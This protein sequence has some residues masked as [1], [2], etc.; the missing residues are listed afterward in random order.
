MSIDY[1]QPGDA[2]GKEPVAVYKPGQI[3][4]VEWCVDNNGDHG[5]MFTYRLCEDQELV[6]KFL[7]PGYMPT[8]AEKQAAEDCFEAGT[9]PCTDVSGQDCGYNPECPQGSACYRN[10]WFT[11]KGFSEGRCKAVDGKPINSCATTIAGGY[12][13]SKK[14]KIPDFTSDHTLLSFKWNSYETGQIYLSCAD[15]A[16]RGDGTTPPPSTT[17]KAP[18]SSTDASVPSST[19]SEPPCSPGDKVAITFDQIAT[20]K[21]GETIKVVGSI[22]ALGSWDVSSAPALSA[23]GYSETK[24]LWSGKVDLKA[25][26]SLEYKFVRVGSSGSVAWESDPNR[27]YIVPCSDS[28]VDG[29]WR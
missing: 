8:D 21:V 23:S 2:W 3:V 6:D 14:I 25:G 11:C 29:K 22:P 27:K 10:D 26:E 19:D 20:T 17:S 24:N 16:I 12:T 15:I 18:P 13:V 4:D 9:L 7:T 1:N 5:G 28:T